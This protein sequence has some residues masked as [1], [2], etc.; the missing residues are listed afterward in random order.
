MG[1]GVDQSKELRAILDNP[2]PA[3]TRSA[4][5]E[6]HAPIAPPAAAANPSE[7]AV[8]TPSTLPSPVEAAATGPALAPAQV[9]IDEAP[10]RPA[11]GVLVAREELITT[12]PSASSPVAEEKPKPRPV[13]DETP[14]ISQPRPA[15]SGLR[16]G[17]LT[18]VLVAAGVFIALRSGWLD[19]LLGTAPTATPSAPV[20]TTSTPASAAGSGNAPVPTVAPTGTSGAATPDTSAPSAS[21]TAAVGDA[22][23][24]PPTKGYLVVTAPVPGQVYVNGVYAGLVNEPIQATCGTRNIRLATPVTPP[25]DIPAAGAWLSPGHAVI[26]ACRSTTTVN[27]KPGPSPAASSGDT[28]QARPASSGSPY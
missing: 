15:S 16:L 23:A 1:V 6:G 9:R 4:E 20:P 19:G 8:P 5:G 2:Q 10:V 26:I 27:I 14:A 25:A 24:L 12:Q 17:L 21:A 22:S 11:G 28:P 3:T 18:A 13:A 7:T